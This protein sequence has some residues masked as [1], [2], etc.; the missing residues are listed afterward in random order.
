MDCC[1]LL[2]FVRIKRKRLLDVMRSE[3][4]TKNL[5]KKC[6]RK[7]N[8]NLTIIFFILFLYWNTKFSN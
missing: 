1:K 8:L 6:T 7:I 2:C 4:S 3:N 5:F